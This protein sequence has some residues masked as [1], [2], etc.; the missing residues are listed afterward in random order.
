MSHGSLAR[1]LTGLLLGFTWSCAVDGSVAPV[2][3]YP[4][5]TKPREEIAVLQVARTGEARGAPTLNIQRI[6][7]LEPDPGVLYRVE[8]GVA[9]TPPDHFGGLQATQSQRPTE[10]PK[11]LPDRFELPPGTYRVEF[12]YVP[13]VGPWGETHRPQKGSAIR[14]ECSAGRIYLL[15]GSLDPDGHRFFLTT[16]VMVAGG[17]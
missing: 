10:D 11:G 16:A 9:W 12:L 8:A 17:G 7:R 13:L 15:K 5:P 2:I 6:T 14:L 1:L 3:L 4:G